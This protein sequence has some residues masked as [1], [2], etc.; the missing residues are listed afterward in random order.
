MLAGDVS[1]PWL[2]TSMQKNV[3]SKNI[4][5][6]NTFVLLSFNFLFPQGIIWLVEKELRHC[7]F[8]FFLIEFSRPIAT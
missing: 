8:S 4:I 6:K 1:F 3:T 7:S 2:H 5:P